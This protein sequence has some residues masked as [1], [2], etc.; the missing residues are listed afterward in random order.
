MSLKPGHKL[1]HYEIV[2]PIGK[3]GMGEVYRARDG[4]L[5]RDVAIKVLP[6]ELA[7]DPERIA[8]FEREAKALAALN[9][10]G[11]ASIHGLEESGGTH[12]LVLELVPGETLAERI[13][14]GPLPENEA[15]QAAAQIADALVEAHE[16][17]IVH[18]DLKPANIKLTPDDKVVVLD[19]GLAKALVDER[20]DHADS[21]S[22]T[23]TR[24]Q[25]RA[26]VIMGTAAYM[27]PEQARGREVDKRADIW[28]FGVVL[29][30][31]LT[32][33]Q[34]FGGEDV[35]EILAS[36]VKDQPAL[37]EAPRRARR[38]LSRCLEKDPKKR[39]R[40][41]GDALDLVDEERPEPSVEPATASRL[42]WAI[43]AL[44]TLAAIAS[45]TLWLSSAGSPDETSETTRLHLAWPEPES[46]DAVV[47][48]V[49]YME[50]SPDGRSVALVTAGQLWVRPLDAVH[51][52][53]LERTEGATYPFWSPDGAWIG[54]FAGNE[55]KKVS[56]ATGLV[57]TLCNAPGSRGASWSRDGVIIFAPTGGRRG[58]FRIPEDGGTAES[59]TPD[60]ADDVVYRYPHFLPEGQDF[61]YANFVRDPKRAGIYVGSL[62]GTTPDRV[63]PTA[64]RASFAPP[65]RMG[66]AGH[67]VF[68]EQDVLMAQPFDARR[69]ETT[70][71]MF[72][73]AEGLGRVG[74]TGYGAFSVSDD[75]TL[76]HWSGSAGS[77]AS[78]LVWRSRAGARLSVASPAAMVDAFAISPDDRRVAIAKRGAVDGA[79]DVWLQDSSGGIPSRFTFS[80]QTI[81]WTYPVWS[82][83]G[84]DVGFITDYQPGATAYEIRRKRAD[85]S[86]EERVVVSTASLVFLSDWSSANDQ[87]LY[88]SG[89]S[90]WT[91]PAEGGESKM[92]IQ[93][94]FGQPYAKLSPD[95]RFLAFVSNEHGAAQVYVQPFPASGGLWQ[96]SPDGGTM[97]MWRSDQ[98]ELYY[99]ASDGALMAVAIGSVEGFEYGTPERLFEGLAA[100]G[101]AG[102]RYTFQAA[103]DGQR[104]LVA[105][106]MKD[107]S[108]ISVVLNW[109]V[110]FE[111]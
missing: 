60:L 44:A 14:R 1:A 107:D 97:P 111:N 91:V 16:R 52:R 88:S 22:P 2:E 28:A 81:G 64:A 35:T 6:P 92:V 4:K 40:D 63:L 71:T 86:D 93:E 50:L 68:Q 108:P 106:L 48:R 76:V 84:R 39:L 19:F 8:R 96:V 34:P 17:G 105:E 95:G 75:G 43:A 3:G 27:S 31:M 18:R 26:G 11:I 53:A 10:P 73:V 20:S 33:R 57:Q 66:N 102:D 74:N 46:P 56:P 100:S 36:V 65:V 69:L 80:S 15:F 42:P 13:H 78:E 89:G 54:F 32:G 59:L 58:L 90:L 110:G 98:K 87:L 94:L 101:G 79:R 109:Q 61:L 37:D 23:F 38:L 62:D 103:S 41:V 24:D 55:L 47:S 70:G 21:M 9:H 99:R 77:R 25:T 5:G 82:P 72:P 104:F 49:K 29:F 12:Y 45:A 83:D 85:M 7:T 51:A 30:E 67:V